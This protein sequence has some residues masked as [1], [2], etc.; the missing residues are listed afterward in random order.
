MGDADAEDL[1][2]DVV[3]RGVIGD[4]VTGDVAAEDKLEHLGVED[5]ATDFI[6]SGVD[7]GRLHSGNRNRLFA[8]SPLVR[9]LL[10]P[11]LPMFQLAGEHWIADVVTE[12]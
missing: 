5:A 6:V 12:W 11:F 3:I 2:D 7:T 10:L 1:K 8:S 9:R 4:D